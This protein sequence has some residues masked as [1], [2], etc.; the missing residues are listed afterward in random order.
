MP[1]LEHVP[2][3]DFVAHFAGLPG[4]AELQATV[5]GDW[6]AR[7][8]AAQLER[9]G[10]SADTRKSPGAAGEEPART[11]TANLPAGG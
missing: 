6:A 1:H 3:G 11:T 7:V 8:G 10:A 9:L 2:P 4:S 5:L